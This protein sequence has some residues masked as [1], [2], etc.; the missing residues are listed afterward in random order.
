MD[1]VSGNNFITLIV[2]RI[3]N[4]GNFNMVMRLLVMLVTNDDNETGRDSAQL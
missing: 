3:M 2:E 4:A 1:A